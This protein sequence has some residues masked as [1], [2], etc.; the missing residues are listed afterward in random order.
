MG[1]TTSL[2]V[3]I[4]FMMAGCGPEPVAESAIP[5]VAPTRPVNN[6][7]PQATE[8]RLFVETA[9]DAGGRPV[10]GMA[11]GRKLSSKQRQAFEASLIVE[12]LPD[13]VDACFIP[14]HFFRYFDA[15][16]RKVGQVSVCFCCSGVAVSDGSNIVVGKDQ[17]V[18]ADY[19][20]L[21]AFVRSL[22]ESTEA[23]CS[24][25]S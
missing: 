14:H 19:T 8:M 18:G 7:F 3:A 24:S 16:G 6:P 2:F 1:R 5:N 13:S 15:K 20:K 12:P 17:Q 11:N 25:N 9:R 22:G 10:F 21:E 4:G 23:Q